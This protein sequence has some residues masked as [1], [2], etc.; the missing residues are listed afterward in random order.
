MNN[1]LLSFLAILLLFFSSCKNDKDYTMYYPLENQTW[2]RFNVLQ[3]EIPVKATKGVYD[4]VFFARVTKNY[5]WDYLDFNMVMTT[6][7]GEE[8]IKE[9]RMSIKNKNGSFIRTFTNDSCE[10]TFNLKR[11]ITLNKGTL[12]LQI[13]NL[14]PRLE[15]KAILGAGIRLHP[16]R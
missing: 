6:P 9:Y 13:E 10:Y 11:G 1:K 4:V 5:E 15:T 2:K 14:I 16:V 12:I 3:Y 7:S 8:R